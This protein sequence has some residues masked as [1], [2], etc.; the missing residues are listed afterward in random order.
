MQ[1]V[2]AY[3]GIAN[4]D[5]N[6]ICTPA[7]DYEGPFLDPLEPAITLAF[8]AQLRDW[9][10]NHDKIPIQLL[11]TILIQVPSFICKSDFADL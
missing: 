1:V 10:T 6:S 8:V 2:E 7:S 3:S 11:Y 5:F 4:A 9:F